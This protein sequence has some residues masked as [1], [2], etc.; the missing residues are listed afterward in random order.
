ML[1]VPFEHLPDMFNGKVGKSFST[2]S[3]ELPKDRHKIVHA[4]GVVG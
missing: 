2:E 1:P 3:D 4:T